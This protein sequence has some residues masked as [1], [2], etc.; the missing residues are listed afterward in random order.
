MFA[1]EAAAAPARGL[2]ARILQADTLVVAVAQAHVRAHG[3]GAV[4]PG[5][6]LAL[7][8]ARLRYE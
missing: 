6:T 7:E 8:V 4:V 3:P 2:S 1:G 5:F